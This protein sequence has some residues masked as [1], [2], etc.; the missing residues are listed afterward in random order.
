MA[1]AKVAI[2]VE[3]E[4][5]KQVDRLVREGKYKNRSKAIQDALE[6]KLKGW[7][8]KRLLNELSKLDPAEERAAAEESLGFE[9]DPWEKY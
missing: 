7:R 6:D 8:K 4:I 9:D 5:L 1:V 3:K 2:T